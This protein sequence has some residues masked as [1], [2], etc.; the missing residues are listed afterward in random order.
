MK[1]LIRLFFTLLFFTIAG[2][3]VYLETER[4]ESVSIAQ[5]KDLSQKQEVQ[6]SSLLGQTDE[7][8]QDSKVLEL[9]MRSSEMFKYIDQKYGLSSYYVS[10]KLD[11]YQRL[12][13]DVILEPFRASKKNFVKKYNQDLTVTYDEPSGTLS[14][15]FV[16]ADPEVAQAVLQDIIQRSD[17]VINRFARENAQVALHFTKKLKNENKALFINSIKAL[18]EYQ[19]KHNTIDP[20]KEVERKNSILASLEGKLIEKEVEYQSKLK[21]YNANALEMKLLRDTIQNIQKSITEIK[22][23]MAGSSA[24][25]NE[26]NVNV[27][28]FELLKSDMEFNKE[29]YRQTL[30][31]QEEL[32]IDVNQNAKHFIIISNPTYPDSYSYPNKPWE[33]LTLIA[34]LIFLYSIMMTVIAIIRDHRD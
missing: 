14:L 22:T 9:Y 11:F 27:F 33:I 12:Y 17:D 32:K 16:H 19:N 21:Y 5:L 23:Q 10:E 31:N 26:L 2:Y 4:Y 29:V 25:V 1:H 15:S 24:N 7:T 8:M 3:I 6:L 20:T 13:P 18:I 34:I 30:I 28:D